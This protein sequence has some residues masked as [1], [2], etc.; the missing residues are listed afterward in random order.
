MGC[1]CGE[2]MGVWVRGRREDLFWRSKAAG[3]IRVWRVLNVFP[4]LGNQCG[5]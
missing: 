1:A 2:R 3:G 5:T 4:V